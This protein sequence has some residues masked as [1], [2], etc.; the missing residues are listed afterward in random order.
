[1]YVGLHYTWES[2]RHGYD[3]VVPVEAQSLFGLGR[4]T[5]NLGLTLAHG[6]AQSGIS[7]YYYDKITCRKIRKERGETN[8]MV[9]SMSSDG[10]KKATAALQQQQ[11]QQHRGRD[12]IK[13]ILYR[14]RETVRL[15]RTRRKKVHSDEANR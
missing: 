2:A 4:T 5:S 3:N 13:S 7:F 10:E 12:Q 6:M 1:M 15:G 14:N 11:Q 9:S 8:K